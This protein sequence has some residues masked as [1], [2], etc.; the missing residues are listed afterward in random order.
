MLLCDLGLRSWYR[1]RTD[2]LEIG[3]FRR[4]G[5]TGS[6][7]APACVQLLYVTNKQPKNLKRSLAMFPIMLL[8]SFPTV[9]GD[10]RNLGWRI[11]GLEQR[12]THVRPYHLS[13]SQQ[14][15]SLTRN[16]Y[17]ITQHLEAIN[18]LQY[19]ILRLTRHLSDASRFASSVLALRGTC[20]HLDFLP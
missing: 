9:H 7:H 1:H 20:K 18:Y 3:Q 10:S 2:L 5:R 15:P 14:R 8:F 16:C 11:L 13:S 12:L 17:R 6:K 4:K 19:S